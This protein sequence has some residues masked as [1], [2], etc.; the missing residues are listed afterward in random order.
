MKRVVAF[1]IV[2]SAAILFLLVAYSKL[3]EDGLI[4]RGLTLTTGSGSTKESFLYR[5]QEDLLSNLTFPKQP[6]LTSAEALIDEASSDVSSSVDEGFVDIANIQKE[7]NEETTKRQNDNKP[8]VVVVLAQMRTGSSLVGEIFN[9]NPSIFYMFEPLHAVDS[10]IRHHSAAAL[11]RQGLS[12]SLLSM[13]TKCKFTPEFIDSLSKWPLGKAKSSGFLPICKASDG[14]RHAS[15]FLIEERCRAF[16]GRIGMKTIRADLNMLKPLVEKDKVNLKVIHLVRDPRGTANSRRSYYGD[17]RTKQQQMSRKGMSKPQ[18]L[19]KMSLKTLGLLEEN[20]RYHINTIS[21]YCKWISENIPLARSRPSWLED[22]YMF[23]R[24]EDL[25]LNPVTVSEEI[26]DFV[27]LTMPRVIQEWLRNNTNQ[28][29]YQNRTFGMQKN[30]KEVMQ[31]W[32]H[33]LPYEEVVQVQDICGSAMAIGGYKQVQ[34]PSDL[35]NMS[36]DTLEPLF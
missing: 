11:R 17:R 13:I 25:A 27:G 31:S 21:K 8:I 4:R 28:N 34:R 1:G 16:G 32:R 7:V 12:I 33:S 5:H 2:C 24:Y 22:R 26:Y 29:N 9:Q 18:V 35:T 19:P 10:F 30:S 15:H 14:C 20:P 6:T 3:S 23:V 36:F